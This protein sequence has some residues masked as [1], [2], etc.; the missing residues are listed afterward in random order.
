M[1]TAMG[2]IARGY[3]RIITKNIPLFLAA[4]LLS[5]LPYDASR[6]ASLVIYQMVLPVIMGYMAGKKAGEESG[7]MAG[8]LAALAMVMGKPVSTILGAVIAGSL[9]GYLV[10]LCFGRLKEKIPVGFEMLVRNLLIVF[11][12]ALSSALSYVLLI[13]LLGIMD[14]FLGGVVEFLLEWKM[15]PFL[16]IVIEPMKIF[17]LNNWVNHGFLVPLGL[18]QVKTAGQSVL[19]LLEANPGPGLGILFACYLK[20]RE[21][22]ET[23]SSGMVIEFLGGIHEVYFPYVLADIR[24]LGAAVAGGF[25][26]NLFF[27]VFGAGLSGP[28]S[29]GSI[30]TILMLCPMSQRLAVLAG[31]GASAVV[32]G[33]TAWFLMTMKSGNRS[34]GQKEEKALAKQQEERISKIQ[35]ICFVCD[36]GIGSSA[37]GAALLRKRMRTLGIEGVL[38]GHAAMDEIPDHTDV[39]ICQKNFASLFQNPGAEIY[40]VEN[41]TDSHEYEEILA[42]LK[43]ES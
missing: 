38:V 24:L 8:T 26:G 5:L 35:N 19:F 31:I 18:E 9:A 43:G 15:L 32:A 14:V 27:M 20:H 39:I 12:G 16:S 29:P 41:L 6:Q 4:G 2:R 13:P 3:S 40:T 21:E 11:I 36:A 1:K 30:V 37:M 17:F 25:V 10:S 33:A 42:R 34:S 28:V 23:L 7:G 22:K